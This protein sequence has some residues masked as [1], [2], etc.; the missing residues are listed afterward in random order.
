MFSCFLNDDERGVKVKLERFL[1]CHLI[2]PLMNNNNCKRDLL[3]M[4]CVC[5]RDALN[6]SQKVCVMGFSCL[7]FGR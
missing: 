3:R 7:L 5:G 4:V 6:R 1:V 2:V